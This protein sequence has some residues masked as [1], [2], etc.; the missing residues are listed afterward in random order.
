MLFPQPVQQWCSCDTTTYHPTS[1]LVSSSCDVCCGQ[2]FTVHRFVCHCVFILL[3]LS[4]FLKVC[5]TTKAQVRVASLHKKISRKKENSWRMFFFLCADFILTRLDT[6]KKNDFFFRLHTYRFFLSFLWSKWVL[7]K[8][9]L[10]TKTCF[11]MCVTKKKII[12]TK[13]W[14]FARAENYFHESKLFSWEK[15]ISWQ[16]HFFSQVFSRGN[17]GSSVS[18]CNCVILTTGGC[19]RT[20]WRLKHNFF[21]CITGRKQE[22]LF[23]KTEWLFFM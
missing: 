9:T 16:K 3:V 2:K 8:E 14:F 7:H 22:N 20:L 21:M 12:F 5:S 6:W 15:K 17:E 4:Q 23:C 10:K 1:Y 18:L 19:T 11:S 13:K